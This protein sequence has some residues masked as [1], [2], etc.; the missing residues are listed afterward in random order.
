MNIN[1]T[2]LSIDR[3][4]ADATRAAGIYK[5]VNAACPYPFDSTEGHIYRN[6]FLK[7]QATAPTPDK[8]TPCPK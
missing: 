5:D 7:A 2:I 3:I 4:E 1:H 6:A 8:A